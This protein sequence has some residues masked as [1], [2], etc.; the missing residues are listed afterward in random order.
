MIVTIF[1]R[2]TLFLMLAAS[3]L[4]AAAQGKAAPASDA[5]AAAAQRAAADGALAAFVESLNGQ[6]DQLLSDPSKIDRPAAARLAGYR[7][8]GRYFD[9]LKPASDAQRQT[10][11][12]LAAQPRLVASLMLA[13]S[14]DDDP[15]RV[16]EVLTA[17]RASAPDAVGGFPDLAAAFC[18]V[19]DDLPGEP[20]LGER[21]TSPKKGPAP[22]NAAALARIWQHCT[23]SRA[24][25][26]NDPTT[27]PYQLAIFVVDNPISQEE[28]NWVL[29]R[30]RGRAFSGRIY[31]QVPYDVDAFYTGQSARRGNRPYTL[32][33][34][35][36]YGGVCNDQAYFA[37]HVAKTLGI[38]AAIC[39]GQ[40]GT[41]RGVHAWTGFLQKK[42]RQATWDFEE[43]RY[44]EHLYWSGTVIDPQTHQVLTD[45][46]V[47]LSAQLLETSP[48]DRLASAALVKLSDRAAEERRAEIYTAAIDLSP[49]NRNAWMALAD[50]GAAGKLTDEQANRVVD[51][52]GRF[53]LKDYPDFAF[54]VCC[55]MIDGRDAEQRMAALEKM[56]RMFVQ[57]PDLVAAAIVARGDLLHKLNRADE[58][59]AAYS[60][61][62][63]RNILAGPIVLTAIQRADALLRER[64]E[65]PR[66]AE[67][68]ETTWRQLPEPEPSVFAVTTPYYKVGEQY[69]ALMKDMGDT[70]KER[71]I[72][73]QLEQ[74]LATPRTK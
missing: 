64:H 1:A 6:V 50:L 32:A 5:L 33:N 58:A 35:L 67:L 47:A 22:L 59:L 62:L 12:W 65:L 16:L 24:K 10:L 29:T 56:E 25:L 45:A 54:A 69:A 28:L 43:A 71:A 55:R 61:A 19:W 7:E 60:D 39:T 26:Q 74:L 51:V 9:T 72:T 63:T 52:I 27:L 14:G 30:Y 53:A 46:D 11:A 34:V 66:L 2:M 44:E 37:A 4:S 73:Q 20:D 13:V 15:A 8:F 48:A 42:G 3:A 40:G 17:L 57:R 68:Y 36:R 38:P 21:K 41:G 70:A 31:Q 18:V 23:L 49:G